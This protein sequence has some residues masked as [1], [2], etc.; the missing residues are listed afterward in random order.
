MHC[1]SIQLLLHLVTASQ[2]HS[3]GGGAPFVSTDFLFT[4]ETAIF[5]LDPMDT[6]VKCIGMCVK[7]NINTSTGSSVCVTGITDQYNVRG[8]KVEL[9]GN[10]PFGLKWLR[11]YVQN[12]YTKN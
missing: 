11:P 6:I 1:H 8:G 4:S 7:P 9:N 2:L 5:V 3:G 12:V 10:L